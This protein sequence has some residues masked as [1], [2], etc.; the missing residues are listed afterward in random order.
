MALIDAKKK[1][2]VDCLI[3]CLDAELPLMIKKQKELDELGLRTY[4]P[5]ESQ[6]ELRSKDQL[7]ELAKAIGCLHPKTQ[8]AYSIDDLVRILQ[9]VIPLPAV[10]K[11]K[12]YKAYIVYNI[13]TAVLKATEIA[14]EWGFPLLVQEMITG[15]EV[16]MI[17][18]S[19]AD[20]KV[21]GRM[22]IKKQLTT[23]LGKVWT[24][25]TIRDPRLDAVCDSF[26][27][28]TKWKGPFE[29]ECM[30]NELGVHLIEINPRFP[31]WVYFASACGVNLPSQLLDLIH[32]GE[33][34]TQLEYPVG[35]YLVR[36]SS[37]FVTELSD[38]Q[39]LL[40]HRNREGL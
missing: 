5:T 22:S 25:V 15:Q 30:T 40:A 3:P 2:G 38:F 33:C 1:A 39:N 27:R 11:G 18:L 14:A 4:L 23:H 12:Y 24:A 21:V 6:F 31:A 29:L 35:K 34:A 10:V 13:E 26:A 9:E 8:L 20:G 32:K 28:E 7:P 19:N 37:E 17:G 36:Y 16:N